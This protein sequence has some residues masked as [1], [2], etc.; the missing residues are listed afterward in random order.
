MDKLCNNVLKHIVFLFNFFLF[1]AGTTILAVGIYMKLHMNNYFDFIESPYLNWSIVFIIMGMVLIT[2]SFFA[3]CG[4]CNENATVLFTY[5]TIMAI[6]LMAQIAT[7]ATFYFCRNDAHQFL[8]STMEK[9]MQDYDE[10][11]NKNNYS[12]YKNTY[13]NNT[14][15]Y[16]SSINQTWNSISFNFK[17]CGVQSY[18]DWQNTTFGNGLNVPT[19]CCKNPTNGCGLNL[20]S[21]SDDEVNTTIYTD[22]CLLKMESF[23]T[24]NLVTIA[25]VGLGM[26]IYQLIGVFLSC[27][28][29]ARM[30]REFN[31]YI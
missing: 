12:S 7:G 4:T 14:D 10:W 2:V 11:E 19:M 23:I 8:S 18:K 27:I 22:G 20:L 21:K 9:Q 15:N 5:A 31:Y 26:A 25:G 29:A 28:L 1:L 3:C 6:F 17:C 30:R 13:L 16:V 24:N